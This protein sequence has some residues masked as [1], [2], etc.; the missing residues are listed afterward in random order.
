MKQWFSGRF[1][2]HCRG[3]PQAAAG[4]SPF[5]GSEHFRIEVY[6]AI[7]SE[8]VLQPLEPE[9]QSTESITDQN[10]LHQSHLPQVHFIDA[11]QRGQTIRATA[12]DVLL[13]GLSFSH[14]ARHGKHSFGRVE[15]LISGWFRPPPEG[16]VIEE[17]PPPE[18]QVPV[19]WATDVIPSPGYSP[20]ASRARNNEPVPISDSPQEEQELPAESQ[21]KRDEPDAALS[22][23]AAVS[24][25][26]SAP[27]YPF[28]T[29]GAAIT[30]FMGVFAAPPAMLIFGP[31]FF[32]A[33]GLRR[34]LLGVVPD[35][36]GVRLLSLV[37]G[38]GQILLGALLL[39]GWS[40]AGCVAL[41]PLPLIL[42]LSATMTASLLPRPPTFAITSGVFAVV[43]LQSYAHWA[44][45][46]CR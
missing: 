12:H 30:A 23:I 6:E 26:P 9:I 14:P 16:P 19:G 24:R 5:A 8:I 2:G 35:E 33:L 36:G 11:L 42:L 10:C 22:P 21:A 40:A 3:T 13:S 18:I 32:V 29:F 31:S 41:S 46:L 27:E 17:V 7:V 43:V 1:I 25:A 15:G 44:L 37:L 38:A 20:E 39:A 28:F 45:P 34:W 4:F